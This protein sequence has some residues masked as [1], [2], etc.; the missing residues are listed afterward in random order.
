MDTHS[1]GIFCVQN[2]KKHEVQD[3]QKKHQIYIEIS[4]LFD[5]RLTD[6][7]PAYL[8]L[9]TS[10]TY[11]IFFLDRYN[12]KLSIHIRCVVGKP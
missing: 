6:F 3:A 4:V 2:V 7:K 5:Q 8:F 1:S 11:P 10:F 12:A 9:E